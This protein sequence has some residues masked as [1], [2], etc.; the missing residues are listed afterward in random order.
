VKKD[1]VF[2]DGFIEVKLKPLDG[3]ED[4]A[5]GLI[6]RWKSGENYYLARLNALENNVPLYYVDRDSWNNLKAVDVEVRRM[7]GRR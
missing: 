6:W 4:Q 3:K 1:A 2:A 7:C 5:G